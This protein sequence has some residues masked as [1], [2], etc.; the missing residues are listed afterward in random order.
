MFACEADEAFIVDT[1]KV[2]NTVCL[3]SENPKNLS[4]ENDYV[5]RTKMNWMK[6]SRM[7]RYTPIKW[8]GKLSILILY[9]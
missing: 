4:D 9:V 1:D 2:K 3:S 8:R 6:T 5:I 7:N